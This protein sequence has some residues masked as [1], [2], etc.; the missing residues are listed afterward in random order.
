MTSDASTITTEKREWVWAYREQVKLL[1]DFDAEGLHCAENDWGIASWKRF[2][3]TYGLMQGKHAT[4]GKKSEEVL[5]VVDPIFRPPLTTSDKVEELT[6]R[7]DKGI[8]ELGKFVPPRK[9]G[10]ASEL[11]SM[12]SKLLWFY[13]PHD[14][15]MF[16]D[17]AFRAIRG[18]PGLKKLKAGD[19]LVAFEKVFASTAA[20]IVGASHFS[21]RKYPYP[22]RVL[23]KWLWL[24]GNKE[25]P[26]YMRRFE[27]SLARAPL[28]SE[29][30]R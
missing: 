24:N 1:D 27:L 23:D 6:Q 20:E 14:M 7:W 5:A 2:R 29:D 9:D 4:L 28:F 22:R 15:T 10:S 3:R 16:D 8:E 26:E 19:Y 17:F 18:L 30:T 12:A 25:K 13:Q 11:R 21:D